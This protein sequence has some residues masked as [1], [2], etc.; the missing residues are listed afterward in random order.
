[1]ELRLQNRYHQLVKA[2]MKTPQ[3]LASGVKS[4]LSKDAA[5]NQTQA[6]WRF[7]N[8]DNC[9]YEALSEPLFK[10]AEELG[11]Q[12]CEHFMLMLHDWSHLGYNGHQKS[13]NDI[14][15]TFKK[16]RGYDLQSSLLISDMH[17]GPLSP[18][19]MNLKTKHDIFS[20]YN[21]K[22][23]RKLTNLEEL[24]QRIDWLEAKEF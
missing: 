20:S 13:K 22:L 24:T 16:C 21:Q 23:S 8:N 15:N 18:V 19:A 4:T 2:H 11:E 12:E 3:E 7:L 1:M 6:L 17:G 5:F 14:Y 10:A 9:T